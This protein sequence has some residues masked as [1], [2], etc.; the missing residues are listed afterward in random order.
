[1]S[2]LSSHERKVDVGLFAEPF[3]W[4]TTQDLKTNKGILPGTVAAISTAM[5]LDVNLYN[6][7]I[8]GFFDFLAD[9]GGLS[10]MLFQIGGVFLSII[11]SIMGSKLNRLLIANLF[12]T[13]DPTK[14]K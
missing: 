13:I 8:Y 14:Q 3:Q 2:H 10:D 12:K 11:S 5:S 1:M 9:V 4:Y 6:R 7:T